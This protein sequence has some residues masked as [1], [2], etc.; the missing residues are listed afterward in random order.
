MLF[1]SRA[2]DTSE[3]D[4]PVITVYLGSDSV[5]AEVARTDNQRQQGL[6]NRDS[7]P[8]GHGMLFIY[9]RPHRLEFWM[10]DTT[11]PLSIAFI[12][13][14]GRIVGIQQMEPESET[15]HRSRYRAIMALEMRQGW[16]QEHGIRRGDRVGLGEPPA[17]ER[18][19]PPGGTGR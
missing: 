17:P 10:K 2:T 9:D 5:R 3:A 18:G 4:L 7:L 8:T 1:R 6:M 11:I 15:I 14:Q 19:R 13:G 16:F 12:D